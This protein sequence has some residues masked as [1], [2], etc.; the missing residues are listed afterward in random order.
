[1]KLLS[2]LLVSALLIAQSFASDGREFR[3]CLQ[4]IQ[5]SVSMVNLLF[6]F[7]ILRDLYKYSTTIKKE[8]K[9]LSTNMFCLEWISSNLSKRLHDK[10]GAFHSVQAIYQELWTSGHPQRTVL[11]WRLHI[12]KRN[13]SILWF[14]LNRFEL[15]SLSL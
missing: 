14:G 6:K 2:F 8:F 7:H 1:M 5:G 13:K 9:S 10:Q 15:F 12:Q 11:R 4:N 3:F